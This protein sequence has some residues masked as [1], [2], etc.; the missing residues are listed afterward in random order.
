M[1][2]SVLTQAVMSATD[3]DLHR[4]NRELQDSV[5]TLK[6][7]L[8]MVKQRALHSESK[9]EILLG[10]AHIPLEIPSLVADLENE[11]KLRDSIIN[12][13]QQEIAILRTSKNKNID[14]GHEGGENTIQTHLQRAK[15]RSHAIAQTYKDH[16]AE[17][18]FSLQQKLS[19]PI[20]FTGPLPLPDDL[21]RAELK[22]SPAS[23][24]RSFIYNV[25]N[26][27]SDGDIVARSNPCQ[28][29]PELAAPARNSLSRLAHI[30]RSKEYAGDLNPR[31][32]GIGIVHS[33]H[34]DGTHFVC[35]MFVAGPTAKS[36]LV[37]VDDT[38]L[39]IDDVPIHGLTVEEVKDMIMGPEG[40][41]VE[42]T[43][44]SRSPFS[45]MVAKTGGN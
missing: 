27:R 16:Y 14:P 33:R 21:R 29:E 1:G 4:E 42:L 20:T 17:E 28:A 32:C 24:E 7:E 13:L 9:L 18:R 41:I 38:L 19:L 15:A 12:S 23:E 35:D 43:V 30:R 44:E 11:I 2:L 5:V 26:R 40:T 25:G 37:H 8:D 6:L 34:P 31:Q 36:G 22:L 45:Y 39:C 10:S 3:E